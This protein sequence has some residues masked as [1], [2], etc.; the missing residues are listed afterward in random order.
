MWQTYRSAFTH[1][2]LDCGCVATP[3]TLPPTLHG[4]KQVAAADMQ[5]ALALVL[6]LPQKAWGSYRNSACLLLIC[7]VWYVMRPC[8][9][10]RATSLRTAVVLSRSP[11]T[12]QQPIDAMRR[13]IQHPHAGRGSGLLSSLASSGCFASWPECFH[14]EVLVCHGCAAADTHVLHLP[15]TSS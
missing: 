1:N 15:V 2:A 10:T 6:W 9:I 12:D 11:V 8:A 5:A 4:C 7:F 14:F 13:G 3:F